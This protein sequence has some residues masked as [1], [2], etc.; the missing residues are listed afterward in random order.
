MLARKR[1]LTLFSKEH[2]GLGNDNQ[3]LKVASIKIRKMY[4][5]QKD[6]IRTA[7]LLLR[8]FIKTVTKSGCK[9]Y[10]ID[11]DIF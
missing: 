10:K 8:H 5:A 4:M 6:C 7:V 1:R 3:I 11:C 2:R 9:V